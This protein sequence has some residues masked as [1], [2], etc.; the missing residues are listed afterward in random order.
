MNIINPSN[1]Q[2]SPVLLAE[3]ILNPITCLQVCKAC[4][5]YKKSWKFTPFI[6]ARNCK[7]IFSPLNVLEFIMCDEHFCQKKE[8]NLSLK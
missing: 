4:F 5:L 8:P 3:L 6:L 1:Q 2:T 7:K